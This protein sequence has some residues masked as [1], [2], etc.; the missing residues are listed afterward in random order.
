[1]GLV[2]AP[3][4]QLTGMHRLSTMHVS[5]I[6]PPIPPPAFLLLTHNWY[7][8]I[9]PP[10]C[11]LFL[12]SHSPFSPPVPA[13]PF[14]PFKL[15]IL[16]TLASELQFL[17]RAAVKGGNILRQ[18]NLHAAASV[19]G[20]GTFALEEFVPET[21]YIHAVWHCLAAYG[22]ATTGALL[23]DVEVRRLFGRGW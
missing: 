16:N 21:P 12:S 8:S 7:S 4:E 14:E 19:L 13:V 23:A 6:S 20:L 1:M 2:G 18:F 17:S 15:S 5:Y 10:T 22:A 9:S 3:S 11:P